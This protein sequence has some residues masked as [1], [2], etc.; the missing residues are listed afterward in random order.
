METKLARFCAEH[1]RYIGDNCIYCQDASWELRGDCEVMVVVF[2]GQ[3][4]PVIIPSNDDDKTLLEYWGYKIGNYGYK[5][6]ISIPT[7]II[8]DPKHIYECEQVVFDFCDK[9]KI[10]KGQKIFRPKGKNDPRKFSIYTWG[11]QHAHKFNFDTF[12]SKDKYIYVC[13]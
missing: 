13:K 1:D 12:I 4:V 10:P 3:E 8:N 2:S 5:I 6:S 7:N 9:F 11:I